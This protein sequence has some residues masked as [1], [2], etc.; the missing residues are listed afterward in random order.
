MSK[1]LSQGGFGCVFYPGV[2]CDGTSNPDKKIVTKVQEDNFNAKNEGR[3]G[4]ILESIPN[5]NLYFLPV[6]SSCP[7]NIRKIDKTAISKCEIIKENT[8]Y[9]AMDIDY[10]ETVNFT[11]VLQNVNIFWM[12]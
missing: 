3:I 12:L 1:L 10:I 7:I 4:E 6:I 8:N 11:E 2:K 5:Y 9:V